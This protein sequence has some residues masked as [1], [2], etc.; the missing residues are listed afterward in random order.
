MVVVRTLFLFMLLA[1]AR[2]VH[3]QAAPPAHQTVTLADGSV[4]TL[5][6]VTYGKERRFFGMSIE[7]PVLETEAQ[8][9]TRDAIILWISIGRPLAAPIARPSLQP[10]AVRIYDD[11]GKEC[12]A[13]EL[14]ASTRY[15]TNDRHAIVLY[16]WPRRSAEVVVDIPYATERFHA[17]T[18]KFRVPN[19]LVLKTPPFPSTATPISRHD[20]DLEVTLDGLHQMPPS[21]FWS[22]P[23]ADFERMTRGQKLHTAASFQYR[24]RGQITREWQPTNGVILDSAGTPYRSAVGS[25]YQPF[26]YPLTYYRSDSN[27]PLKLGI[28][29]QRTANAE[30]A[31]EEMVSLNNLPMRLGDYLYEP[32]GRVRIGDITLEL[33][34]TSQIQA[35]GMRT[36]MTVNIYGGDPHLSLLMQVRNERGKLANGVGPNEAAKWIVGLM[37]PPNRFRERERVN[38]GPH[39][40]ADFMMDLPR[41]TSRVTVTIAIDRAHYFEFT[42]TPTVLQDLQVG[43]TIGK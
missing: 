11:A 33:S 19:P 7:P 9:D 42:P 27:E 38:A 34:S 10:G 18:A 29:F 2:G 37:R 21:T 31:P 20:N 32:G 36:L 12:V 17:L 1:L 13:C 23:E 22:G 41:G 24:Y 6:G 14:Q 35:D 25:L 26:Q 8:P 4:V 5:E 3:T 28:W 30:F 15:L 39:Q 43:Q 40:C 16:A